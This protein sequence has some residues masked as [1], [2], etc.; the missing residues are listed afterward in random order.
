MWMGRG[1]E[2]LFW[3]EKNEHLKQLTVV[4]V[5]VQT[6]LHYSAVC[7]VLP[8]SENPEHSTV[9]AVADKGK[10]KPCRPAGNESCDDFNRK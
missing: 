9:P 4:Q 8:N 5:W 7:L 10:P 1:G 6:C 2:G 3:A